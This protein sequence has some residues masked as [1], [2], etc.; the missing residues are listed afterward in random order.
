MSLS[1][2][3]KR[4]FLIILLLLIV[5]VFVVFLGLNSSK[6]LLDGTASIPGLDNNVD[7]TRD[8]NGVPTIKALSRADAAKALGFIHGQ[9]RFF[10]MDLL[11]RNSA[12]ELSVLF[13]KSAIEYDQKIRLHQF[14]NRAES[15]IKSSPETQKAILKAYTEGVNAGLQQLDGVPFEYRLLSQEPLPW[16]QEDTLLAVYSM[17]LDL[18]EN[19]GRTERSLSLLHDSLPNDLFSFL[20]P[21]G[22]Q[23]D[24]PIDGSIREASPIPDSTWPAAENP[25]SLVKVEPDMLAD[26]LMPGSN[27]WAVSHQLTP[28]QSAMLADDMHLGIRVP[29]IWYR[30][31]IQWQENGTQHQL[32]GVT[33]PG[34][35]T[36]VVGSNTKVAWGF[37]NSY[38]DWSDVIRLK[39]NDDGSQYQTKDGFIPFEIQDEVI[40]VA[41]EEP[42]QMQVKSTLWG[43]VIGTDGDD[44][45]LVYRWI[46]HDPIA[47][48]MNFLKMETA[49]SVHEAVAIA[50]TLG[51]PAQNMVAA[52]IE[53]NISWTV[54]GTIPVRFGYNGLFIS[55]W[56]DGSQGWSGYLP[57]EQYPKVVNPQQQRIWTA[58]SRVVGGEMYDAIGDGGYALGARAK[59]I[60]DNLFEKE[61]FSEQDLLN[62]Q[63]DD[64]AVFLNRWHELLLESVAPNTSHKDKATLL[65]ELQN[66]SG[67]AHKDDLGYLLVRQFRLK[68]RS[69]LFENL[70]NQLTTADA[71]FR[72]RSVRRFIEEPMW[73]MITQ[74]PAHLI[75][76][77]YASWDELLDKALQ[78][79]LY[80]L[81][82]EFG[83]WRTLTWGQ[84]NAVAIKHPMS[85]FVPMLGKLTDMPTEPQSGDTLMPRVGGPSFGASQRL[86]VAP[87][88]EDK[89]ILHMP[90]SQASHPLLPYYG[91][92][93]SDWLDGVATPLLPGKATY[94]LTLTPK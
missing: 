55:D 52:D 18:Q 22:G 19:S 25:E 32:V 33:L 80:G 63:L 78:S 30:A 61:H 3:F 24:A 62:I 20:Y 91:K 77:G 65:N 4:A 29:I 43:P 84:F 72:F 7:I 93:H 48:N 45:L 31:H 76:E 28:Y 27:N 14:R 75:P 12:G 73:E 6:P 79:S 56:S 68:V 49:S 83:D 87:G 38:G 85:P 16:K 26:D 36:L 17:Y 8:A 69:L 67:R 46:A 70:V 11:R 34:T 41:G 35:P 9:E 66:W 21:K 74:Q 13:G 5:T 71:S 2:I 60:R 44:N 82:E 47:A 50:P 39:V 59:Q 88:H 57:A 42:V 10:Q 58:N 15:G 90:T 53:G 94:Q 40:E 89:G 64:R 92:G 54:T 51:M 86:V 81:D 23:W 37:T 1:K